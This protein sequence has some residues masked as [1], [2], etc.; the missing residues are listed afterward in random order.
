MWD[1]AYVLGRI[2]VPAVFVVSGIGK[3][4]NVTV[5]AK[6]LETKGFPQ[7]TALGYLVA[8]IEVIGGLMVLVGF[9]TRWAALALVLFTIATIL[10]SHNF[11]VFEGAQRLAQQSQALKNLAIMGGL[12]MI[13]AIGPGRWSVDGR[14]A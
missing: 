7:P 2:M 8:A 9:K 11:W 13:A 1:L 3:L 4:M 10:V 5:I 6:T 14:R 12:L